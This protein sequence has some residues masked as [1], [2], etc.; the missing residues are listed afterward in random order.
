MLYNGLALSGGGVGNAVG[1]IKSECSV[2]A[3][4]L[5]IRGGARQFPAIAAR[6]KTSKISTGWIFIGY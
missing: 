2:A 5:L 4:G 3:E 1:V 6:A